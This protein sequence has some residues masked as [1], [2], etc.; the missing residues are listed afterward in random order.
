MSW[1]YRGAPTY[2]TAQGRRLGIATILI[3]RAKQ[4]KELY[5]V[6]TL[7]A[8]VCERYYR[9]PAGAPGQPPAFQPIELAQIQGTLNQC[10]MENDRLH[11]LAAATHTML[12]EAWLAVGLTPPVRHFAVMCDYDEITRAIPVPNGE[13]TNRAAVSSANGSCSPV[14]N[15]TLTQKVGK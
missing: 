1:H 12:D 10:E 8:Q 7:L 6:G 11:A 3:D 9:A 13:A 14:S 4:N 5:R 15:Q 2:L